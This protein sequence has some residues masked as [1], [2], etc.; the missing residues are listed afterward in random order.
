MNDKFLTPRS[1][2]SVVSNILKEF[3]RPLSIASAPGRADFLNTHQ[4]YKGLPVIPVAVNLRTYAVAL[5]ETNEFEVISLNMR[6]EGRLSSDKFALKPELKGG[7][8]FGD[9]LRACVLSLW[10]AGFKLEKGLRMVIDSDVPAGGGLGS[11]AA[12]EVA[13]LK[14]LDVHF[15]FGLSKKDLSELA[16]TA[17]NK[18]MGIPCGRLDQYGSSYG[19]AILLHTRPPYDVEEL[20]LTG[21]RFVVADSGIKHRVAA[22]HPVRQAEIELGLSQLLKMNVPQRLRSL[23]GEK[24]WEPRW[25]QLDL[26]ELE[27]YLKMIDVK[28]A[29]RIRFTLLMHRSTLVALRMIK[30]ESVSTRELEEAGVKPGVTQLENLGR[31][32]NRQHELLRDLYEVSLPELEKIRN[33]MLEAGAYGVKISGAGLGGCL[34]ALVDELCESKVAEAALAAGAKRA[35]VVKVDQGAREERGLVS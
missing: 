30:G 15:G 29:A 20:P 25:E 19:G 6:R 9:Y 18:I 16:F 2:S 34:I 17:E 22:I 7:G 24:Y 5:K 21:L 35:W 31:V 4:D 28:A 23:L 14:L 26:Y 13:F 27:D 8:H 10:N 32:M 12:L 1:G 33:H 11:S 3:G